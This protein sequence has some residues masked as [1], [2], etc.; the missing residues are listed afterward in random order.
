MFIQAYG[1]GV[2]DISMLN[3]VQSD[4][5]NYTWQNVCPSPISET[6]NDVLLLLRNAVLVHI[7]AS[8]GKRPIIIK[9]HNVNAAMN[10]ID[11]FPDM[12]TAGSIYIIRDPRDVAISFA[13]HFGDTIDEAIGRMNNRRYI[14][15]KDDIGGF[16]MIGTW[17]DNVKSWKNACVIKYED[18]LED[19]K[20]NF[21][22]I[23]RALGLKVDKRRLGKAIRLCEL[24]RVRKQ[25]KAK[26]FS[27]TSP[28]TDSFFHHGTSGHWADI[29]STD[30]ARRIENDH[31]EVMEQYGYL[32]TNISEIRSCQI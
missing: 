22:A 8:T 6:G 13:K 17:S 28:K 18:L 7:C 31:R 20:E 11:P 9:T 32:E 5:N 19:P 26:P 12:L 25:E 4:M 29:L 23:L 16:Q 10:G 14:L 1:T 30:Q 27:E 24:G 2:L 21:T 3:F 15:K